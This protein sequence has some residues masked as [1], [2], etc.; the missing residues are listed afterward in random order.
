MNIEK[1]NYPIAFM[2]MGVIDPNLDNG[3]SIS[4]Q[5][6]FKHGQKA[7]GVTLGLFD[8]TV[9]SFHWA[10]STKYIEFF[11][12]LTSGQNG[13]LCPHFY[14]YPTQFGVE[15]KAELICKQQ[16]LVSAVA[17]SKLTEFF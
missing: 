8:H 14:P 5:G 4:T 15:T 9:L 13:W 6:G 1:F 17:F 11:L 12:M 7:I 2:P 16:Q 3:L 10:H